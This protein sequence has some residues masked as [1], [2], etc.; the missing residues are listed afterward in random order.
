MRGNCPLRSVLA[1]RALALASLI[2]PISITGACSDPTGFG[3]VRFTYVAR[4]VNGAPVPSPLVG[5]A[6]YELLVLADTLRLGIWGQ[7]EWTHVR[8]TTVAGAPQAV[9]V[10]RTHSAYRVRGDSV[11]FGSACRDADC[12]PSPQ[13]VFTADRRTLV[14]QLQLPDAVL[15]YERTSP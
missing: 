7:A 8:R 5:N 3:P 9:E 2:L 6:N 13:G 14:V 4:S 15:A 1:G 10:A 11:F 12:A